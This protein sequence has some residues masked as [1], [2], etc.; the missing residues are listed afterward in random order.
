MTKVIIENPGLL[1]SVQDAGRYGY[2]RFGMPVSGAMDVFSMQLAN[3][4]VGNDP[5]AACIEATL[6][7]P[8]IRFA[9]AG[10]IALCGAGMQGELNGEAVASYQALSVKKGDVLRFI[11]KEFG[12]R[13]Y[14]ACAGGLDVPVV[15]GSRSTSLRAGVGGF[16]GRAL[17]KG[18][19]ISLG[20]DQLDGQKAPTNPSSLP[21][22]PGSLLDLVPDCRAEE[23]VR[24]LPGPEIRRLASQG[25]VDLLSKGFTVSDHSDRMGYRLEGEPLRLSVKA[26]DIVS[27]GIAMGTIQVPGNGRPIILMAD[28]QTTGGYLRVAVVA[29]IDLCRVAQLRPGDAITFCEISLEEAQALFRQRQAI[30]K[31]AFG[32]I[33]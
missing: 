25:V 30:L 22:L 3:L 1:S 16:K 10:R 18:D 14:I 7:G 19:E 32:R 17:K 9:A 24:I 8:V 12:C 6:I 20:R 27:A 11:S 26:G 23:P 28:R 4:L 15:M 29:S 31:R 33:N 13:M 2:Q 21:P 5:G